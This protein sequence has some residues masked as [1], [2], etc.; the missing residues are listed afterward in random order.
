MKYL[1]L[2]PLLFFACAYQ[3]SQPATDL[4]QANIVPAP[5]EILADSGAI[6][7]DK[8]FRLEYEEANTDGELV[9]LIV[10]WLS[11]AGM[12]ISEEGTYRLWLENRDAGTSPESYKLMLA[13]DEIKLVGL[14]PG[15]L[16]HA[17]QSLRQLLLTK[18]DTLDYL[19]T[20]VI[21]DSPRFA[22]RGF[23]LDVSRHFFPAET[24]ERVIDYLAMYKINHLHLHLSDDQ[25]W[26]LEIKA[27][28][29]LTEIGGSTEVDGGPGGFYTQVE[30]LALQDYAAKR[31]IT[32]VPEF[33]LPGH[34]NAAL[35]SYAEL[36]CDGNAREL[37]TGTEV[38]FS[39]LCVDKD[40]IY[41]FLDTV[42]AEVA[43]VTMGPFIHIG[44]DEVHTLEQSKYNRFI[45][46]VA[47]ITN[48]HG[49]QVIGWDEIAQAELPSSSIAQYWNFA[50]NAQ[51]A[52]AQ[53]NRLI[54]SPASHAYLDMKYDST[55][56]LGLSW[57]G[58][59]DLEDAYNWDPVGMVEG[60]GEAD[61]VGIE[62]PLWSETIE[63]LGDIEYM[64]FPRIAA[65]SEVAWSVRDIGIGASLPTMHQQV[66]A[67]RPT[68]SEFESR[69]LLH[70]KCWDDM[71]VNF[72]KWS[73]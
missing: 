25:G 16:L 61:I 44:G 27:Y 4:S 13:E 41:E 42:L 32:I 9:N 64:L 23:M 40:Y 69:L 66:G 14:D 72:Y 20:G 24:V 35:A 57:A 59:T 1:P 47:E 53:G 38:G 5:L 2:L 73:D 71:G 19:P 6:S 52:V 46:R 33:D 60:V 56:D 55:T 43:Q 50:E 28:P 7:L 70:Q 31:G 15:G 37:Y 21:R 8:S 22:Y 62:A 65:I 12:D 11:E 30:Y 48:R 63:D 39:C 58:Y 54:F 3:G 36:N 67:G 10:D 34:T 18:P 29:R 26:R 51:A 49:K 68:F 45:E 17:A